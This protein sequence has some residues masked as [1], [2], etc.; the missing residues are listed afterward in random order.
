MT[1]ETKNVNKCPDL[2][3]PLDTAESAIKRGSATSS[4]QWECVRDDC[5]VKISLRRRIGGSFSKPGLRLSDKDECL[6]VKE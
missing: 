3:G 1:I 5:P 4:M 6:W 2:Q